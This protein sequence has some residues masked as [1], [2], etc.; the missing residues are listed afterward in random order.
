MTQSIS[1]KL[2]LLICIKTVRANGC[3]SE[4]CTQVFIDPS[5]SRLQSERTVVHYPE[6]ALAILSLKGRCPS[7]HIVIRALLSLLVISLMLTIMPHVASDPLPLPFS[8][9]KK[10]AVVA[11]VYGEPYCAESL[12]LTRWH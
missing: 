3:V 10:K 4:S 5:S 2:S 12:N 7:S 11:D 9:P 1:W 6:D 8:S